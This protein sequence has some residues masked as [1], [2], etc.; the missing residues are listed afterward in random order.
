MLEVIVC[1]GN[2]FLGKSLTV[3]GQFICTSPIRRQTA[4][5]DVIK[6]LP[7]AIVNL[8][9]CPARRKTRND[10]QAIAF[11]MDAEQSFREESVHPAG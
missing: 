11:E 6:G 3:E 1:Q 4:D 5:R 7:V 2:R 8:V 9:A 10:T